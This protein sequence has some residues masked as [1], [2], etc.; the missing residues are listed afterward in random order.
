MRAL[1]SQSVADHVERILM[2]AP[3]YFQKCQEITSCYVITTQSNITEL[4]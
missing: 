1:L 4:F 2:V 3:R